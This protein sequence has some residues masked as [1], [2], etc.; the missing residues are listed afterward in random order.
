VF[1][2]AYNTHAVRKQ[3][4]PKRWEDLLDAKWKGKLGAE[5]A[6]GEWYCALTRNVKGA[7]ELFR[8]IVAR[9]GLSVHPGNSVLSN[10]VISGQVPLAISSYTHI[11]A[12]ARERG[13]PVDWFVI[14]PLI[15]R[16]NGVAVSRRPP[17]PN[18]A[19]LFYEYNLGESQ[20]LMVK[21]NYLS[22]VRKLASPPAS[23]KTV[24][25]DQAMGEAEATRCDAAYDALIRTK[26]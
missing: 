2:Q 3:D 19:R 26:N 7:D 21:L 15:L 11:L 5:A 25:V 17:H 6:S 12:D 13:A 23:A 20:P 1:V 24:F 16:V 22:P 18:A 14:E 4:L 8:Q 9:N 10:M